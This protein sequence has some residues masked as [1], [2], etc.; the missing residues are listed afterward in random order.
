[1]A[2]DDSLAPLTAPQLE[3]MR[4]VWSR[5]EATVGEV[6]DELRGQRPIARNTVLTVMDRL[7]KKGWL[8]RRIEGVRHFYSA[9]RGREETL[10]A[11][12]GRLVETAFEG[13]AEELVVALLDG[14]G[15]SPTEAK[16]IRKLIDAARRNE[17]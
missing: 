17:R 4:A 2:N 14:R 1:M 8:R 5:E 7:E 10:G 16:R 11:M 15:V 13:S 12:V 9:A 3:V 6:W